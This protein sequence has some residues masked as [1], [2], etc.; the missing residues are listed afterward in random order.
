MR[1]FAQLLNYQGCDSCKLVYFSLSRPLLRLHR[2]PRSQSPWRSMHP[3]SVENA[4]PGSLILVVNKQKNLV[5]HHFS[6]CFLYGNPAVRLAQ[7]VLYFKLKFAYC[8]LHNIVN[9]KI[10]KRI[11]CCCMVLRWAFC[12]TSGCYLSLKSP[13]VSGETKLWM[14]PIQHGCRNRMWSVV[15]RIIGRGSCGLLQPCRSNPHILD[16]KYCKGQSML[17]KIQVFIALSQIDSQTSNHL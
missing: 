7:H 12:S 6:V 8:V 14:T 3:A 15:Q 5:N 16:T 1:Q 13:W 11:W 10:T 17:I 4:K 2:N 9:H